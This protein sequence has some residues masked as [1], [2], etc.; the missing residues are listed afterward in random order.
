MTE[1]PIITRVLPTVQQI[2][3]AQWDALLAQQATPTPFM[4][5]AYLAAMENSASATPQ[6]GW[7][8]HCISLWQGEQLL[9]ACP[10]YI[11]TH[12]WGEYVFDMA[13]ARAY[14]AH[15]FAYYPKAVVAVPFTPVPGS[16]LLAIDD[17]HRVQLVQALQQWCSEQNL[18]SCH[19]LFGDAADQHAWQQAGW[20]LREGVQF[21]WH[22]E[23]PRP[24][25]ES[26]TGLPPY[27]SFDDFLHSLQ[28]AKR[29]KIRQER[30]KVAQAGVTFE[31]L[32]GSQLTKADWDFFYACYAQTYYEHGN[33]PYLQRSFFESMQHDL[34]QHW[35]MFIA[36]QNGQ[37]IACSLIAISADK[38]PISN[39]KVSESGELSAQAAPEFAKAP[40]GTAYGRYWGALA[41]VD[42]LHFEA[43]YYQPLQ[44][45]IENGIAH[46]EGGAQGEHKMA[47]AL[48]PEGT[49]S[50]HWL[51]HPGFAEAV[52]DFLTQERDGMAKYMHE[53][54][55]HSP[56]RKDLSR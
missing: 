19:I 38:P 36:S 39:T 53:L 35:V 48:L 44:W 50:G 23:Q 45:C 47:R 56:L 10:V 15:G 54:E 7:Q 49:R 42:A 20:L 52:D 24:E 2:D 28:Q 25:A 40:S 22:N 43:C 5:H 14:H 12:S 9:A 55:Q 27:A 37:R 13:W 31:V 1:K 18:S 3:A 17:A 33:P 41:R 4:R 30:N 26:P 16:R 46:F 6:T 32:Q 29:K 34:P 21:H 11:K 8:P 51:A